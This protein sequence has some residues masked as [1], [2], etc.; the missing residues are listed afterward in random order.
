[1]VHSGII[2]ACSIL[3]QSIYRHIDFGSKNLESSFAQ[4]GDIAANR[5]ELNADGGGSSRTTNNNAAS[6]I[7]SNRRDLR[8]SRI[9]CLN[10]QRLNTINR[11]LIARIALLTKHSRSRT[12]RISA[13][14]RRSNGL[15]LN[16]SN[17]TSRI[18][19]NGGD[20]IGRTSSASRNTRQGMTK[21]HALILALDINPLVA[22]VNDKGIGLGIRR[23]C[24]LFSLPRNSASA[25]ALNGNSDIAPCVL[26]DLTAASHGVLNGSIQ[27]AKSRLKRHAISDIAALNWRVSIQRQIVYSGGGHIAISTKTGNDRTSAACL[28][29]HHTDR[30]PISPIIAVN[31]LIRAIIINL[32]LFSRSRSSS[33]HLN[34]GV[35]QLIT[36]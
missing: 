24:D 26:V 29:I 14:S 17:M 1:M 13:N 28:T 21:R 19:S 12:S 35:L 22:A 6:R 23:K 4:S 10:S 30:T 32:S 34:D 20:D 8:A 15:A 27:C 31:Q 2:C 18:N 11:S 16:S 36:K 25:R 5:V 33:Q 3:S 7:S 9:A